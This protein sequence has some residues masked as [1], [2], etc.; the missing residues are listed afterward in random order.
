MGNGMV[1]RFNQTLIKMLGTLEEKQRDWKSYVSTLVHAYNATRH[2]STGYTPFFLMFGRHPR[3]AIDAYL[4]LNSDTEKIRSRD[5]YAKK[6]Q[7]RLQFSYKIASREA[8]KSA[9]RHKCIMT[10]RLEN[11]QYK[12]EIEFS[13]EMLV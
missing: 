6:L 13:S 10:P 5:N 9:S 4:R 7:K 3:L 1:E 2:D 8:E 11:P 12:W